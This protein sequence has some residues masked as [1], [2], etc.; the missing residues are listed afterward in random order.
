MGRM[1]IDDVRALTPD[2]LM[3]LQKCVTNLQS[4]VDSV[5]AAAKTGKK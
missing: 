3:E 1:K 4:C 5:V 2:V